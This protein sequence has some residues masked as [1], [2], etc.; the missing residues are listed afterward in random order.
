MMHYRYSA[1]MGIDK[2]GYSLWGIWDHDEKKWFSDDHWYLHPS[3]AT[4][5]A[6]EL[7][8]RNSQTEDANG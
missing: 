3:R 4:L 8:V 6:A 5:E 1:Q 7:N 2:R